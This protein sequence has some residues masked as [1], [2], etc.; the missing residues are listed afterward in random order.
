MERHPTGDAPCFFC[1][2]LLSESQARLGF[3]SAQFLVR[4]LSD[5]LKTLLFK[6]CLDFAQTMVEIRL[7]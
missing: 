4:Q 7:A 1:Q 6:F 5:S 2:F 3:C